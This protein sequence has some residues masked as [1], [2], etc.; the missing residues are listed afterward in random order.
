DNWSTTP[1]TVNGVARAAERVTAWT[2]VPSY[3]RGLALSWNRSD[4]LGFQT[5]GVGGDYRYMRGFLAEQDYANTDANGPTTQ[6]SYGGSQSLSG[7]FAT[8]ILNP[9]PSLFVEL[10]ARFDSWGNN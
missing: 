7:V 2:H 3:D 10:S 9:S 4:L 6:S 1:R 5:V 8:G